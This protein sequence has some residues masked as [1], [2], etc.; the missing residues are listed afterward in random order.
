MQTSSTKVAIIGAGYAGLRAAYELSKQTNL[1]ITLIDSNRWH[2]LQPEIY[3][4]LANKSGIKDVAIDLINI[5]SGLEIHFLHETVAQIEPQEQ[6]I[7]FD[8]A[9][10]LSYD[11]LIM[12]QGSATYFPPM[13]KGINEHAIDIKSLRGALNFKQK[14]ENKLLSILDEIDANDKN[15]GGFDVVIG[16][17]GLSGVEIAAEMAS[18]A[19]NY[20]DAA[21]FQNQGV[22]ICLVDGMEDILPG[23]DPWI[24]EKSRIQLQKL[25]VKIMTGEFIKELKPHSLVLQNSQEISYDFF[26]FTG[27]T[28]PSPLTQNLPFEKAKNGQLAVMSTLQL[29]QYDTIYA[30][31]DTAYIT[32][33]LEKPLPPTSQIAKQS[34]HCAV[35]NIQRAIK[36]QTPTVFNG[37]ILGTMV[38]LGENY[39][40]GMLQNKLRV[41]GRLAYYLK[42]GI[43]THY[44]LPLWKFAR[45]GFHKKSVHL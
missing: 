34:A 24:I 14:F 20:L 4:F 36:G 39:A 6:R 23:Q 44:K 1:H 25:G 26:I 17:A 30:I 8:S 13:I 42:Q 43:F 5:C 15:N 21:L 10:T 29:P 19:K 38:A 28:A 40:V 3:H 32:D 31:G 37:K 41:S 18:Y 22:R 2:Y 12:A 35:T 27:G 16:G 45:K 7:Q 9:N 33:K 11:Y